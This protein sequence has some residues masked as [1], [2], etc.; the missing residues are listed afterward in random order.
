ICVGGYATPPSPASIPASP[1]IDA[2]PQHQTEPSFFTAQAMPSAAP[3]AVTSLRPGTS[4][5]WKLSGVVVGTPISP[6]RLTPQQRTLPARSAHVC[7]PPP[8]AI[9]LT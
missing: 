5:A 7:L 1:P 3:I 6:A 4:A 8:E 2:P 9:A